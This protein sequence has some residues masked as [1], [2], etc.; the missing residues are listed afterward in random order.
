MTRNVMYFATV[1]LMIGAAVLGY[2]LY[3]DRQRSGFDI[4]V[5]GRGISI[6]ER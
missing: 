3:Q 4:T 6:Q 2:W 5:G 1:A